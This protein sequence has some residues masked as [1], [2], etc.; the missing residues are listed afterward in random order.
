MK[1]GVLFI[2][3]ILLVAVAAQVYLFAVKE[4]KVSADFSELEGKI[5]E[6]SDKNSNLGAQ[7]EYYL[8]PVNLEKELRARFNYKRP[9]EKVIIIVPKN[10]TTTNQ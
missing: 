6:A 1:L 5:K 9:G 8:N 4:K 2:L 7:L 3:I 10:E